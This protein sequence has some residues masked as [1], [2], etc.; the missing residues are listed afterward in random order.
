MSFLGSI[1]WHS[2]WVSKPRAWAFADLISSKISLNSLSVMGASFRL[3]L[4]GEKLNRN[5]LG[6]PTLSSA[7]RHGAGSGSSSLITDAEVRATGLRAGG[8]F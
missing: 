1:C 4:S 3:R 8:F 5:R 6:A 7:F 2:A